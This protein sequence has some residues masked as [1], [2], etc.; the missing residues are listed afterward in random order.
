MAIFDLETQLAKGMGEA[1]DAEMQPAPP[2]ALTPGDVW[3]KLKE[4]DDALAELTE[5]RH[6][7]LSALADKT[8]RE[9]KDLDL[10]IDRMER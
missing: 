3:D 5:K 7:A 4:R 9:L 10:L 6:R 1:I 8:A 2:P